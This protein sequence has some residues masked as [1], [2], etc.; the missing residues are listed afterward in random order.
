MT[1]LD[2]T[3]H[4][5]IK[6][7]RRRWLVTGAAGFIGSHLVEV[8]LSLGQDVI[9]LDNFVTGHR[10]NLD[11]T[12]VAVGEH[13]WSSYR[14]IE[15]DIVD[16]RVCRDACKDVEFVL[17]QAALGSVPRSIDNPFATHATNA[18]GFLNI[19]AS[20]RDA[21]V[22]RFIYASS[23]SV[24]GDHP[25]LPKVEHKIGSPL[26]PYAASKHLNELYA[27]S[28]ARCYGFST[29]GLRYF[30]VF[31][32]RQDPASAYA[33]VIPRWL[34]AMLSGQP[35]TIYGDGETSR[36]FC[37]IANAVQANLRAALVEDAA[38]TNQV[39]N[40]ASGDRISLNC[41]YAM[42]REALNETTPDL[43]VLPAVRQ[44]FRAGDVRHSQADLTKARRLLGYAPTHDVRAGLR[45]ALP[46]YIAR[47]RADVH[48]AGQGEPCVPSYA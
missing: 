17:H 35:V 16:L 12:R 43:L 4:L 42:L 2:H 3:L 26:S 41:L 34:S 18:T 13:A 27:A 30:N 9:G 33:A 20:A 11:E 14:F 24:Y 45:T 23:S 36:D 48:V 32:S 31:G 40:V 21:G 22:R 44:G 5:Q 39:Y 10:D 38:A 46:W 7:V 28:F 15:G 19:L 29:I 6:D 37:F 8:L 25:D 1:L 47:F